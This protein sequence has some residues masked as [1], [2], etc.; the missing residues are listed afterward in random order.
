A[1]YREWLHSSLQSYPDKEVA[2][3]VDLVVDGYDVVDKQVYPSWKSLL[4]EAEDGYSVVMLTGSRHSAYDTSLPFIPTLTNFVR[5]VA[6]SAETQHIKVVGICFG[7]QLISIAMG[8]ECKAGEAGWEIGVYGNEVTEAGKY[9]WTGH[10]PDKEDPDRVY[11]Q[12]MHR[13]HVPT[14]P[15]DFQILSRSNKYPIHSMVKTH[16]TCTPANP[17]AQIFSVQ[18]HPEYTP[19]IVRLMVDIRSEQGIFDKKTTAEAR[20]RLVGKDGSGGEGY[21]RVGWA[22]W[23]VLLQDTP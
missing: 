11:I 20:R 18:G 23:R 2:K 22:I 19:D 8:G 14:L 17:R 10:W 7:H 16:P 4:A 5:S 6:T 21:G 1:I 9:W 3:N 12:Q 13:D 15:P